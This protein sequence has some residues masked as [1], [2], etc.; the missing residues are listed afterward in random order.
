MSD[1]MKK[2]M[3]EMSASGGKLVSAGQNQ[4]AAASPAYKA[5]MDELYKKRMSGELK[6]AQDVANVE[7]KY[8]GQIQKDLAAKAAIFNSATMGTQSAQAQ[9]F[10]KMGASEM[11]RTGQVT[12]K[13]I[14]ELNKNLDGVGDPEKAKQEKKDDP[15]GNAIVNAADTMNDFQKN[16]EKY[17]VQNL[18]VWSNAMQESLKGMEDAFK[19]VVHG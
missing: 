17:V 1:A 2:G 5:M 11:M 18:P 19:G 15:L 13:K 9:E 3:T 4:M 6:T 14:D 16:M 8:R 12:K 10:S 7:V